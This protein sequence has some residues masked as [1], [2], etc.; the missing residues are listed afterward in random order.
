MVLLGNLPYRDILLILLIVGLTVLEVVSVEG[1]GY[2]HFC[3]SSLFF[4]SLSL[5]DGSI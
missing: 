5:E 2:F 1:V 4:P 3:P